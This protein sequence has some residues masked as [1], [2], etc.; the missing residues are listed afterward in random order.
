MGIIFDPE[1]KTE[2]DKYQQQQLPRVRLP[3]ITE[4]T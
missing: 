3:E 4:I 1:T 2:I